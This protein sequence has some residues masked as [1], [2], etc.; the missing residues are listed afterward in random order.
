MLLRIETDQI[1]H[2]VSAITR[3]KHSG[4]CSGSQPVRLLQCCLRSLYNWFALKNLHKWV[5]LGIL[6]GGVKIFGGNPLGMQ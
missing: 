6:G 5:F 2:A 3:A 4:H 1:Y